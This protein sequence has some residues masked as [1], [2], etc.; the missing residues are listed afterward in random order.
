MQLS[1]KYDAKG[2]K[3]LS[4]AGEVE[5]DEE[6]AILLKYINDCLEERFNIVFLD[7]NIVNKI[8]ID[9]LYMLQEYHQSEIHVNKQYLYA[10]LHKLGILCKY[11][12]RGRRKSEGLNENSLEFE[13]KLS[14]EEVYSFLL[15]IYRIYGYDYTNYQIDSIMRR[16]KIS[17]LRQGSVNFNDFKTA[18]INDESLFEQMFIN[19]SI[20]TTE[21]FRDPEVFAEI[22]ESILP[23]LD[24]FTHIKIWCAGCSSGQEPYSLAIL[25]DEMNM[26]DKVQIYATDINPYVIQEAKNGLYPLAGVEKQINNYRMAQGCKGFMEYFKLRGNYME[27]SEKLKKNI[28]FFQHSLV[29][30]GILNEFQLILCRNVLIYLEPILQKNILAN[31]YDSLDLSGFLILGKSEGILNNNGGELFYSHQQPDKK[32]YR[33]KN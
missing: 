8:I 9:R 31:F 14:N 20:N 32:I 28:L 17:M 16:I 22:R 10:Y 25:L 11:V 23:Y 33:K 21:F 2:I 24:S 3:E 5:T 15:D 19:F 7:A 12:N 1:I 29:G 26:L 4:I 27:I 30:S 6:T 13:Y 18:V